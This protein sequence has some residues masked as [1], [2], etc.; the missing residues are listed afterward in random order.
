MEKGHKEIEEKQE[1]EE[2][3]KKTENLSVANTGGCYETNNEV[4][5]LVSVGVFNQQVDFEGVRGKES[6]KSNVDGNGICLVEICPREVNVPGCRCVAL[7]CDAMCRCGAATVRW[8]CDNA[9]NLWGSIQPFVLSSNECNDAILVLGV[10]STSDDAIL[11]LGVRSTSDDILLTR[12][13]AIRAWLGNN[14]VHLLSA[15][16]D[17][18]CTLLCNTVDEP[19]TIGTSGSVRNYVRN[20]LCSELEL[21][22]VSNKLKLRKATE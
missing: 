7:T 5:E 12:S 8:I 13:D 17:V 1:I 11:L 18:I 9:L 15:R 21:K 16:N 3:D 19:E 2:T 4:E 6:S 14:V 10:R 20:C 22:L